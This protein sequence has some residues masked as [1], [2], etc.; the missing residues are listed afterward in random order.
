MITDQ[1]L[2]FSRE[3]AAYGSL[4]Y[5]LSIRTGNFIIIGQ[6]RQRRQVRRDSLE[7]GFV[8]SC[9]V[10]KHDF[11]KLK[12]RRKQCKYLVIFCCGAAQRELIES[13]A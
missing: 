3:R 1:Q 4:T 2:I 13:E 11:C 8:V 10:N 6:S 5:P 12:M 7:E 9:M